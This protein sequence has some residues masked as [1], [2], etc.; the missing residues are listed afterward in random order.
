L[1]LSGLIV[2]TY[3]LVAP[4][5]LRKAEADFQTKIAFARNPKAYWDNVESVIQSVEANQV[6]MAQW[7]ANA[8]AE[9]APVDSSVVKESAEPQQP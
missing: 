6:Q 2:L 5:V 3:L 9:L 8:K 1:T 7:E 4:S